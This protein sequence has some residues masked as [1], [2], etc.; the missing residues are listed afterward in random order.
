MITLRV[1]AVHV[2]AVTDYTTD[3]PSLVTRGSLL[4]AVQGADGQLVPAPAPMPPM[5]G[6][7]PGPLLLTLYAA[8]PDDVQS[9]HVG[10]LI[11]LVVS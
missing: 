11:P 3:P 7:G 1:M 6:P 10:D 4:V 2:D 5:P 9:Y 8:N